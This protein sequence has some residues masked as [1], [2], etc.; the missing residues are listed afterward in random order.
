MCWDSANQ[1]EVDS[2]SNS[3]SEGIGILLCVHFVTIDLNVN[4][5]INVYD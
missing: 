1:G 4:S 2:K 5:D 3:S